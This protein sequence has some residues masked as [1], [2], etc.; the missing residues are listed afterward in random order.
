LIYPA[1]RRRLRSTRGS[2][3]L[4]RATG[5]PR[6][7]SG[8]R[9][10][11]CAPLT[12]ARRYAPGTHSAGAGTPPCFTSPAAQPPDALQVVLPP[13][14]RERRKRPA[15]FIG[16]HLRFAPSIGLECRLL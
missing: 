1:A 13:Y 16:R 3:A 15:W 5:S 12:Q 2:A 11:G 7:L 9:A 14:A 10:A 6:L 8:G 4:S